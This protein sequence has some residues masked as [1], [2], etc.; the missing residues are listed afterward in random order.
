MRKTVYELRDQVQNSKR[1]VFTHA[2]M[3]TILGY[4]RGQIRVYAHR[5]VQKGFAFRP[6]AGTIALTEDPYIIA[7][8]LIEPS[9]ISFSS[10]MYLHEITLQ[11]PSV[12][13]CVTTRNPRHLTKLGIDYHK[14]SP[15]LFFGYG[16]VERGRSYAFVAEP[17][18]A[19]L[20]LVYFSKDFDQITEESLPRL[21]KEKLRRYA[22]AFA[23]S[24]M[25]Q[26]V[27]RWCHKYV[28]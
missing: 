6:M 17:E 1:S 26:R 23:V 25:G 27:I 2:Q 11:V 21:D 7:S 19:M 20:D 9:Y 8:Q 18:K 24:H 14:I 15:L 3:A 16:R 22:G 28:K 5:F 10:A 13:E 4:Q 12:V